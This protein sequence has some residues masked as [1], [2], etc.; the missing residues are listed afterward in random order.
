VSTADNYKKKLGQEIADL[1]GGEFKFFKSKLELK[2]KRA[3]GFDV[4]VLSGSNKW[5]PLVDVS[6]YFGRNFDAA[7][8]VEKV[9][10]DHPMP[11]Q[12]Q[13][14]S[15]NANS[16][17]GLGYSGNGTW[18]VNIE[19]PTQNLA[20]VLKNAI[21]SIAFPFFEKFTTLEASQ[22]ALAQD[23]SWCFSPKGPFYHMLFKVDAALGD[24]EHFKKWSQCL[25]E[26]YVEQVSEKIS[27]L[28]SSGVEI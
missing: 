27:K 11:Y 12:I 8:K 22:E 6:F 2:R 1:F 13:Q 7:R 4:I 21:E 10:G 19:E 26:F 15:P 16:M 28:E 25:D 3:D 23:H 5:S 17:L 18:E 24:L 9:L 14:Y 20:L